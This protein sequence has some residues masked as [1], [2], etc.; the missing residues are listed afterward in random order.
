MKELSFNKLSIFSLCWCTQK[1][2]YHGGSD[3]HIPV[4]IG[5]KHIMKTLNRATIA[6]A[7]N[8][9]CVVFVGKGQPLVWLVLEPAVEGRATSYENVSNSESGYD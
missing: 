6:K 9:S 2:P 3:C 8:T 4:C 1:G 7:A 5:A